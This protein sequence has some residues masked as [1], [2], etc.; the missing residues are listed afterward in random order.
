MSETTVAP[1]LAH[2]AHSIVAPAL[3]KRL[4][5]PP[6]LQFQT[7]LLAYQEAFEVGAVL[8]YAYRKKI[9]IFAKVLCT[10]GSEAGFVEFI[11]ELAAKRQANAPSATTFFDLAMRYELDRARHNWKNSGIVEAQLGELESSFRMPAQTAWGNIGAALHT[12][13]GFGSR[14]PNQTE[15]LWRNEHEYSLVQSSGT[16]RERG[17]VIREDEVIEKDVTLAE[18]EGKLV[19]MVEA[20][21]LSHHPELLSALKAA[22]EPD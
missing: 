15:M 2:I 1:L 12:G 11:Q 18:R 19:A 13:I 16:P 9:R 8:G 10:S 7:Y 3:K 14:F 20:F 17:E 22:V 6:Y 4:F 5:R 21:A